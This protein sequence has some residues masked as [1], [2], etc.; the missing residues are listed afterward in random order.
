MQEKISLDARR[1]LLERVS[2]RY[3]F[4][5]VGEDPDLEPVL[6]Y[7]WLQPQTRDQSSERSSNGAAPKADAPRTAVRR[8]CQAGAGPTVE[9]CKLHLFQAPDSVSSGTDSGYGTLRAFIVA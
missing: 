2:E 9:G 1:E 6:G 4:A 8:T 5:R 7:D 3:R